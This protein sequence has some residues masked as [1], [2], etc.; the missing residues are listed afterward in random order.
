MVEK[1]EMVLEL[2]SV[3]GGSPAS[4]GAS[5]GSGDV[6]TDFGGVWSGERKG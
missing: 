6:A 4:G 3:V 1:E 2:G 5:G